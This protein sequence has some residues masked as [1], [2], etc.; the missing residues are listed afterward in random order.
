MNIKL[1]DIV[2]KYFS[3]VTEDMD[4]LQNI[5]FIRLKNDLKLSDIYKDDI[6]DFILYQI[7]SDKQI[8]IDEVN[9]FRFL[10]GYGGDDIDSLK[11]YIEESNL[12]SYEYQSTIPNSLKF[13]ISATNDEKMFRDVERSYLIESY[14]RSFMLAGKITMEA[15]DRVSY[16]EKQ[17]FELF[18][19]NLIDYIESHSFLSYEPNISNLLTE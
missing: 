12:M 16:A 7:A 19:K 6:A 3:L 8:N 14:V 17:D 10:T 4:E 11:K 9:A 5:G 1:I 18:I 15:D 13:L 2:K